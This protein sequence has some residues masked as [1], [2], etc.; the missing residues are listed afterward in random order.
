MISRKFSSEGDAVKGIEWMN[1]T[2]GI[3]IADAL[4]IDHIK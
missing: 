3:E 2:S 4:S 1:R